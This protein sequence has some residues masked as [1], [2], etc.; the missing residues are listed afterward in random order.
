MA[1]KSQGTK[2]HII[3]A[4]LAVLGS[5]GLGGLTSA[6]VAQRAGCAKGL[7]NYHYPTRQDLWAVVVRAAADRLYEPR[8]DAMS[9]IGAEVVDATWKALVEQLEGRTWH[10]WLAVLARRTGD[11]T[12]Q[13]IRLTVGSASARWESAVR[14]W[15]RRSDFVTADPTDIS[16]ATWAL[17]DGFAL[18]LTGEAA[19][20]LYPAYLTAWLGLIASLSEARS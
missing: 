10:V 9:G 7:I 11:E 2:D 18:G 13:T 8:I 5:H 19:E 20:R 6:R 17:L 14:G 4:A 16:R 3:D 12:D 15:L 1:G